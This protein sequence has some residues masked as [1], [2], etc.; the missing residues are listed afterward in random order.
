MSEI[1][2]IFC[3]DMVRA[4]L[5]DRKSKTRRLDGLYEINKE[6]NNWEEPFRNKVTGLWEF[7]HKIDNY[8]IEVKSKYQ[9]G[10]L[11]WVRESYHLNSVQDDYAAIVYAT[12]DKHEYR[13][14]NGDDL[15]QALRI[16]H[17][18]NARFF[19]GYH[20]S[21]HMPRWAARIFREVTN[22][23][24]ERL[25][26]I[27]RDDCWAEGMEFGVGAV[28]QGIVQFRN[29]W[30]S[31]NTKRGFGWEANP[32]VWVYTFKKSKGIA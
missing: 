5:D 1:P 2:I 28:Y 8:V 26:D 15:A 10:D 4:I 12:S 22:V 16:M 9:E 27:S 18:D 19:T 20:P 25:Q 7:C 31:L 14:L 13:S 30:D 21:I 3:T 17:N 32:Y 11:L 29:L 23:K 24:V 6:P